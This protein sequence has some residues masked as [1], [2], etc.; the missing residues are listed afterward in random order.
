M[1]LIGINDGGWAPR[2]ERGPS[3]LEQIAQGVD[4]ASKILGVGLAGYKT[5]AIDKPNSEQ[6][7]A[8]SKAKAEYYRAQAN[9]K[10]EDAGLDRDLKR[11]QI[12][13]NI[14][15]TQAST[16]QKNRDLS[17]PNLTPAQKK[18]DE[19]FA[20]EYTDFS[21]AGG[22]STIQK[23]LDLLNTAKQKLERAQNVSGPLIGMQP[24]AVRKI[25]NPESAAIQRDIE[26]SVQASLRATLGSQFTEREGTLILRR[27]FDPMMSEK[28]NARRVETLINQVDRLAKAK[29]SAADWFEQHGTMQGF[30][31][32]TH[33]GLSDL[34]ID[35]KKLPGGEG[36]TRPP[37]NKVHVKNP[38]TGEEFYIDS[39]HLPDAQKDG[40]QQIK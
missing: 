9:A 15:S 24:D 6:N 12:M 26:E 35:L 37:D 19:E 23:N 34:G 8:E 14:A 20:K 7:M 27:A 40:F 21:L 22:Y 5:F 1:A 36:S 31:G 16:S 13:A 33:F 28:E 29:Q 17:L 10:P 39:S 25:T 18:V 3:A 32:K 38:A 4:V 11:S 2:P 30:K